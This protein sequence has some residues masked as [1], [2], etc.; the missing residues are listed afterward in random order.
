MR[1]FFAD[2]MENFFGFP[3]EIIVIMKEPGIRDDSNKNHLDGFKS[4]EDWM[5]YG[6][7]TLNSS[8]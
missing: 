8:N 4:W 6:Y 7:A 2:R 5:T 1:S 3:R